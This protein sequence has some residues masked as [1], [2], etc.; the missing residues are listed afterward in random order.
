MTDIDTFIFIKLNSVSAITTVFVVNF[1]VRRNA[2]IMLQTLFT[3]EIFL[4]NCKKELFL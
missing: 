3:N 1:G 4:Q 2:D